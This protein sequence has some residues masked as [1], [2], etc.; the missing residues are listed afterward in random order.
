M[1]VFHMDE[2]LDWEGKLLARNDPYNFTAG[3]VPNW[4]LS[5]KKSENFQRYRR[6]ETD[7]S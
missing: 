2:C 5:A 4:P 7:G 3:S 1:T 6:V